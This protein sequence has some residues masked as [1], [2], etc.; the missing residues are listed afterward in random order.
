MIRSLPRRLGGSDD[1]LIAPIAKDSD[2][3]RVRAM[4]LSLASAKDAVLHQFSDF[5]SLPNR[6]R[7][8][9]GRRGGRNLKV[10]IYKLKRGVLD[11][12]MLD[13]AV[14][15]GGTAARARARPPRAPASDDS[16]ANDRDTGR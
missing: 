5:R 12:I 2:A 6:W 11:D 7:E 3:L 8:K 1:Y 16:P 14:P 15:T 10:E 9:V 4:A 13:A